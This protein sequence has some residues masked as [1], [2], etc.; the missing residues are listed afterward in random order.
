MHLINY[1]CAGKIFF[2]PYTTIPFVFAY[3]HNVLFFAPQ[4]D[5]VK[6]PG[7]C[8]HNALFIKVSNVTILNVLNVEFKSKH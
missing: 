8:F 4:R 1:W 6:I 5:G 3:I 2:G 7:P